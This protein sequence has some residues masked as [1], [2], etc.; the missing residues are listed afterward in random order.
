MFTAAA[1]AG[2]LA[3]GGCDSLADFGLGDFLSNK[4]PLPGERKAVFP[5]GV[6]GVPQGVPREM[7]RGNQAGETTAALPEPSEKQTPPEKPQAEAA[8]AAKPKPKPKPKKETAS[9]PQ[10][11]SQPAEPRRASAPPVAR[12]ET[13][14]SPWPAPQPQQQPAPAPWPEPQPSGTFSR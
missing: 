1:L 9:A 3:C 5:E 4:K 13:A 14:D 2:A 7:V 12:Q 11:V 8:K 10:P 6:P